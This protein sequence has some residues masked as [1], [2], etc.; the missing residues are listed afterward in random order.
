ML[1]TASALINGTFTSITNQWEDT[2]LLIDYHCLT[3]K[4][5]LSSF[6]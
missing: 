6:K 3:G 4:D 2:S 5:L 1:M